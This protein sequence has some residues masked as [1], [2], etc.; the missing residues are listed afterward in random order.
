[1]LGSE[2]KGPLLNLDGDWEKPIKIRPDSS[3]G[4]A[5]HQ[6]RLLQ[7]GGTR[8]PAPLDGRTDRWT[9]GRTAAARRGSSSEQAA[10]CRSRGPKPALA[11]DLRPPKERSCP[12]P[13]AP[14]C[15][16]RA[17]LR[18]KPLCKG[19]E[20]LGP[21]TTAPAELQGE[22]D[23]HPKLQIQQSSGESRA[24]TPSSIR[25]R[26][27]ERA[28]AEEPDSQPGCAGAD[29]RTPVTGR[30]PRGGEHRA[31]ST[32]RG[33]VPPDLH[34]PARGVGTAPA[35]LRRGCFPA[36]NRRAQPGDREGTGGRCRRGSPRAG[37]QPRSGTGAPGTEQV[38]WRGAAGRSG[39]G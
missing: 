38:G 18:D 30:S 29:T 34:R 2:I 14:S 27:A 39:A 26:I 1:M 7:R 8:P 32:V 25:T 17:A 12:R 5:A 10:G 15:Q 4:A 3:A 24:G 21:Q 20:G 9:D 28:P 16:G 35:R 22:R 37:L 11:A 31:G 36:S 6:R 23:W 19:T 33:S 13:A